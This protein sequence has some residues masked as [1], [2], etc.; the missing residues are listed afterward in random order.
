MGDGSS[1]RSRSHKEAGLQAASLPSSSGFTESSKV[2]LGE[3]RE[4]WLKVRSR[5]QYDRPLGVFLASLQMRGSRQVRVLREDCPSLLRPHLPISSP[6]G[7][8]PL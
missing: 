8:Q 4:E 7:T 2:T 6:F 3:M 5:S 1:L